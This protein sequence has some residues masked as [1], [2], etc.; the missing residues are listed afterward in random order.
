[1]SLIKY[2]IKKE[3]LSFEIKFFF[4]II[5]CSKLITAKLLN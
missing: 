4:I 1:M 2:I 5:F 3:K